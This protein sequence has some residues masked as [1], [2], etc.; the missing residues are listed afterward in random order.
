MTKFDTRSSRPRILRDAG[1]TIL[2]V[3]N[4]RYALVQADGYKDVEPTGEIT[5]YRTNRTQSIETLPWDEGFSSESQALDAAHLVSLLSRVTGEDQLFLTVRGRLRSPN[6]SF[7]I[8]AHQLHVSG[9]QIEVDAGYEGERIYLIEAKLGNREDF[10]VRQLYY[11]YRMWLERGV[12]KEVIPVLVASA[13][14]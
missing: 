2:A 9:V 8:G 7:T 13:R 1:I 10:I 5:A 12:S 11:P 3:E 4:G 14:I 6:Y